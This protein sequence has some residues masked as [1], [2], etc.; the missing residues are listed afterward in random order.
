MRIKIFMTLFCLAFASGCSMM[1]YEE[2][3]ACEKNATYGKCVSVGGAYEEAVTGEPQGRIITKD[4]VQEV[5]ESEVATPDHHADEVISNEDVAYAGY[6]AELYTQLRDLV[7]EPET[8]M[9]RKAEQ[10]RTLIL[11]YS[12]QGQ[13]HRLYMPRYIY[14]IHRTAEFVMGQ[15]KLE[16][17]PSMRLLKEFLSD[18]EK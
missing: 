2:D 7:A 6:R 4:G 1:P 15:Y 12:P 16:Q 5:G 14:S 10:N 17:D 11:S 9:V 8:P 18:E 3:F 13:Q